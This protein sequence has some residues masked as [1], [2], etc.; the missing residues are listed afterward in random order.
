MKMLA[1]GAKI[2]RTRC[3]VIKGKD[4]SEG[5]LTELGIALQYVP[6][7]SFMAEY[8]QMG[9]PAEVVAMA[10]AYMHKA[11]SIRGATR[12]DVINGIKSYRVAEN[13]LQR[14]GADAISMDCL[15]ALGASKIS[16]PCIAWS[17]MNDDGIPAACE[18]DLGAVASHIFVQAL[19]DRPGFQQ[20]P[21]PDTTCDAIIGAHCSCP[22]KLNGFDGPEEPFDLMHHHGNRDAVPR[23]LWKVG[24]RITCLDVLPG[25]GAAPTELLVSAGTV[26]DNLDVPPAG[27]CV[28]SVRAKFDSNQ[29]VLTFPGFH[30]LFFYGDFKRELRDF[31]KLYRLKAT[32]V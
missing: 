28:V 23:T 4:R 21:V 8:E 3:V 5:K 1:A 15:G 30:Q 26:L 31:A 29:D 9:E 19:F 17:R 25:E 11:R 24:Q 7:P 16:L 13:I 10:D 6:A 22:T 12:Q 14:E 27:G 18:A 32:L 20:D 2:H